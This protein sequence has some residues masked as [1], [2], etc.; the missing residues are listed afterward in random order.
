MMGRN[1][2]LNVYKHAIPRKI[3]FPG[4]SALVFFSKSDVKKQCARS[5]WLNE[6]K[7]TDIL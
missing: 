1:F 5:E 6:R 3:A 4:T 2:L 7:R